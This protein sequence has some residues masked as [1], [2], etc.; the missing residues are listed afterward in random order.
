[1]SI[2]HVGYNIDLGE[3][4]LDLIQ[5][6]FKDCAIP[7]QV[8][9]AVM[10]KKS[11]SNY[12]NDTSADVSTMKQW[13]DKA[14]TTVAYLTG[15]Y[16]YTKSRN[17]PK[18]TKFD[19]IIVAKVMIEGKPYYVNIFNNTSMPPIEVKKFLCSNEPAFAQIRV[20]RMELVSTPYLYEQ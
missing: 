2:V 5:N 15:L 13:H 16:S 9:L 11:D 14:K 17:P 8:R 4:L 7:S 6:H 20:D 12:R 18:D 1:M 10:H 19:V 3:V